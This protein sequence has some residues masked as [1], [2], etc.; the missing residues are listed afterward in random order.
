MCSCQEGIAAWIPSPHRC[1]SCPRRGLMQQT[2]SPTQP[3]DIEHEGARCNNQRAPVTFVVAP[4]RVREADLAR[5]TSERVR[6]RA[7][8]Q[9]RTVAQK[10]AAERQRR[11]YQKKRAVILEAKGAAHKRKMH[12]DQ[13]VA[14]RRATAARHNAMNAFIK[15]CDDAVGGTATTPCHALASC[16]KLV[17]Q[18]DRNHLA[19]Q[20]F[21]ILRGAIPVVLH[22][23][24]RAVCRSIK[25][26]N[27]L[28]IFNNEQGEG[29]RL[30]Y[31][32]STTHGLY[33]Q[34]LKACQAL[35]TALRPVADPTATAKKPVVLKSFPACGMQQLHR[36]FEAA[37]T[38]QGEAMSRMGVLIALEPGTTFRVVPRT[39]TQSLSAVRPSD[40]VRLHLAP[41]DVVFF[42][43]ALVHAG[44]DFAVE[45]HR[46]H[47]YV[48]P[49]GEAAPTVTDLDSVC[50]APIG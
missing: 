15:R 25:F 38:R 27:Y 30:Q 50:T 24:W 4:R 21:T 34:V 12:D 22:A 37:E 1:W 26:R 33:A 5:D 3:V 7:R 28:P 31:A 32:I 49:S 29:L 13:Y 9:D 48:S 16:N 41:G 2:D 43:G 44:D 20:G 42:A 35:T 36:D 11:Y 6:Q 40:V 23:Q 14:R 17:A 45:N 47:C 19:E 10:K 46:I 18:A 8:D 39:H